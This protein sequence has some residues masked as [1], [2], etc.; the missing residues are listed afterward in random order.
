MFAT[1]EI[2]TGS[3]PAAANTPETK[4][5][6][7]DGERE[8]RRYS[9]EVEILGQRLALRTDAEP[10]H[11][12]GLAAYVQRKIDEVA[13]RNPVAASRLA[14]LA[15]LN[16]ADDYYRALEELRTLKRQVAHK[17]RLLLAELDEVQG[18]RED[19]TSGI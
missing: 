11:V 16:I 9:L 14:V 15:A 13:A 8:A 18:L 19:D 10:Q 7:R 12:A 5:A 6:A 2:E 4:D 1:Q 3:E 17:S